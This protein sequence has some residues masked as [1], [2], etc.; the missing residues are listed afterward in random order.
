MKADIDGGDDDDV[1]ILRAGGTAGGGA[2]ND[3]IT[4]LLDASIEGGDGNDDILL[5]RGGS[6]DGGDG[7]DKIEANYYAT[8]SGGKG[9]DTV[10]LNGG[11]TYK[12]AKGDG[13]DKVIM[14]RATAQ[15][16]DTNKTPVNRIIIDGYSASEMNVTLTG[17]T[18]GLKPAGV[19]LT[20]DKIDVDREAVGNMEII[21]RKNGQQQV[22]KITG[23]TQTLGSVTPIFDQ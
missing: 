23:M 11:G 14:E 4:G 20:G 19:D 8:V 3:T 17:L 5:Y 1:L 15:L 22:L 6:A 13:A 2:G 12:F 9:A 18:L 21:F 7:D 10:T 16:D